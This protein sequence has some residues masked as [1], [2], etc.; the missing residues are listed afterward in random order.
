MQGSRVYGIHLNALTLTPQGGNPVTFTND[1]AEI[2]LQIE[3]RLEDAEALKDAWEYPLPV[4]RRWQIEL[5][6]FATETPNGLDAG[7]L[8]ADTLLENRAVQV[9]FTI[10]SGL[11]NVRGDIWTGVGVV[12]PASI[13]VPKGPVRHRITIVGQ[14]PLAR[15]VTPN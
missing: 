3:V 9:S 10:R 7:K 1:V 2:N 15:I 4:S 8:I 12:A 14:G 6:L 11:P 13:N 5:D